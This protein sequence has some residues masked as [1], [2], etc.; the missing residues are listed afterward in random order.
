MACDLLMKNKT[1]V[2]KKGVNHAEIIKDVPLDVQEL[3]GL[4]PVTSGPSR[5]SGIGA[6]Q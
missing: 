5:A 4:E 1:A 6:G 2:L 3:L